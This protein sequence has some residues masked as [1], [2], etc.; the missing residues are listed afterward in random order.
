[1]KK[2]IIALTVS[3][4]AVSAAAQQPVSADRFA[5]AVNHWNKEHGA[6]TYERYKPDRF[7]EIA[8]NIVAYQNADGGWPK[9]LDMLARLDPDSV[10]AALKPRHR[11]STL[12]NANVYTQV[13]YLSNVYLLT[14]DTLYR[15]SARRGMEYMLSA[16]YPNGGWRGWDADAVT[17]NDGIIYGVLSTWN[18]VLS[19]KPHYA[20]V[21]DDLKARIRASWD[22]GIDLILKTQWVQDG[23]KTVWAQQYDHETL[24]PVKALS[25]IHISEPTRH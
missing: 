22:R 13:E 2:G 5:D 6:Q 24:Q 15:N 17:F 21:G 8:D 18:E 3:F 12:D 14:G 23:V 19:G 10:K 7:R 20:W 25:L 1:M 11:L 9:N 16:Q 4:L